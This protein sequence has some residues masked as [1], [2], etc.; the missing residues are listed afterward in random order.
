MGTII[1]DV[2]NDKHSKLGDGTIQLS[3]TLYGEIGHNIIEK[4]SDTPYFGD[5]EISS[6]KTQGI[7]IQVKKNP[8]KGGGASMSVYSVV[9][10]SIL[11]LILWHLRNV[12]AFKVNV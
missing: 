3:F 8:I 12:N 1:M 7:T 5:R 10:C 6:K 2:L 9:L 11:V 4:E